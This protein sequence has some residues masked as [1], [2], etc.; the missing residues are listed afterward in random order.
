MQRKLSLPGAIAALLIMPVV[1]AQTK[2]PSNTT[3]MTGTF[4]SVQAS[5][6]WRSSQMIGMPVFDQ[7][8]ERIGSITDLVIDQSGAVQAVII[9]VGGFLG[10]GEKIIAVSLQKMTILRD[11]NGDK[12]IVML[13]KPE[14][15]LAPSFQAF[16]GKAAEA[17]PPK[18][19]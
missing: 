18:S 6:Q 12:A 5:N 7:T 9:G 13:S 3:P 16:K 11:D 2:M 8:N 1:M 15:E 10:M 4:L 17:L 19:Q 14:I